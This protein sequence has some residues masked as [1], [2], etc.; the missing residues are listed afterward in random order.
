MKP[1]PLVSLSSRLTGRTGRLRA[2]TITVGDR[3]LSVTADRVRRPLPQDAPILSSLRP[4]SFCFPLLAAKRHA[5]PP[6]SLLSV[7]CNAV[8][9]V[10]PSMSN[11]GEQAPGLWTRALLGLP[12][13]VVVLKASG[14]QGLEHRVAVAP[15]RR[16]PPSAA[17]PW[18]PPARLPP[19]RGPLRHPTPHLPLHQHQQ[20]PPEALTGVV[21]RSTTCRRG[22]APVVSP[23]PSFASNGFTHHRTR[24]RVASPAC[25]HRRFTGL[26]VHRHRAAM[27]QALLPTLCSLCGPPARLGLGPAS[28]DP[29]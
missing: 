4:K 12:D 7:R 15:A 21:L 25:S 27:G 14:E 23:C 5:K 28:F 17:C 24:S 9:V 11:G 1:D 19:P 20:S 16:T 18:L 29:W 26:T 13:T 8:F 6:A 3:A 22:A 2:R 10:Q